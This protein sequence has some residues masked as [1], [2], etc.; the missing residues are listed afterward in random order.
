MAV[1]EYTVVQYAEDSISS[2]GQFVQWSNLGAGDTGAP[3]P[4]TTNDADKTVHT[5][6]TFGTDGVVTMQG[7]NDPRVVTD[8]DNAE[9]FPLTDNSGLTIQASSSSGDIVV[10]SP[11]YIRPSVS[12]ADSAINATVIINRR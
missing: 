5:F 12:G 9:W 6:G 7:S 8:P 3:L 2:T 11:R 10:E 4:R 1:V